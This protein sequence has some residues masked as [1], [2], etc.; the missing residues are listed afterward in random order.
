MF[1]CI[2]DVF[3]LKFDFFRPSLKTVS[4][5]IQLFDAGMSMARINLSHGDMKSNLKLI[6]LYAEAKRLRPHKTCA[7]MLDIQGREIRCSPWKSKL[8]QTA[9]G[10]TIE[11]VEFVSF[12]PDDVIVLRTEDFS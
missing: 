12:E 9:E 3:T 11:P 5:V 1:F 2:V 10:Q 4:D 8:I 6:N 7:I